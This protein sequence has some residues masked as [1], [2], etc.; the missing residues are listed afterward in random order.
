[1]EKKDVELWSTLVGG[2]NFDDSCD[3]A[4]EKETSFD[5]LSRSLLIFNIL[6]THTHQFHFIK[7]KSIQEEDKR[8]E[9]KSKLR[10]RKQFKIQ[11]LKYVL[12]SQ[13]VSTEEK[14]AKGGMFF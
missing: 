9:K 11:I 4:R 8:R 6:Q 5:H 3:A 13:S 14:K 12:S 1:M 7:R 10:M 2:S